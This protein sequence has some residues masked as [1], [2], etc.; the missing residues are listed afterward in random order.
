MLIDRKMTD[1]LNAQ[2]GREFSAALQY[3]GMAAWFDERGFPGFAGF[4]Y[5]Q[6][7]EENEH[8]LK[9]VK[10]LGEVGGKVSIPKIPAPRTDYAKVEDA[11]RHFVEMEEGVTRAI[12]SLV[13]I[14]QAESDHSANQFLQWYVEE[15]REEVSSARALLERAQ[16]FGEDRIPIMDGTLHRD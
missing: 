7:E 2:I 11:L 16:R 9:I 4:F 10:Y 15:Q 14:A 1:E 6:A 5:K 13:E 8:G 3:V 12:Y